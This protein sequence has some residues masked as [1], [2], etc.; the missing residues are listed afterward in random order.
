MRPLVAHC[1]LSL[2][3]LYG[4][5]GESEK[6]QKELSAAIDLYGSIEMTLGLHEAKT[7]L[8]K[9]ADMVPVANQ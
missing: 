4:R 3:E 5:I 6:A 9:I 2:G 7:A 8:Q 1:H